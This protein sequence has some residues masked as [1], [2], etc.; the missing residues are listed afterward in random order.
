MVFGRWPGFGELRASIDPQMAGSVTFQ[1]TMATGRGAH[2]TVATCLDEGILGLY[3]LS[4]KLTIIVSFSDIIL[5][6][7]IQT[8]LDT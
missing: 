8:G 1:R 7:F 3:F 4:A 2:R 5:D 6:V